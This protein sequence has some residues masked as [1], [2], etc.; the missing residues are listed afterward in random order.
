MRDKDLYQRILGIEAPWSVTDVELDL[1]DRRHGEVRVHVAGSA[2]QR[3]RHGKASPG[4]LVPKV[5]SRSAAQRRPPKT[6]VAAG[7]PGAGG[8]PRGRLPSPP[9]LSASTLGELVW[10]EWMLARIAAARGELEAAQ[11]ALD[12]VRRALL[13]V[14]SLREAASASLDLAA[15]CAEAGDAPGFGQLGDNL[16]PSFPRGSA[17]VAAGFRALQEGALR[18]QELHRRTVVLRRRLAALPRG[19]SSRPDLVCHLAR[20]VDLARIAPARGDRPAMLVN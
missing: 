5:S 8:H 19:R 7:R 17:T 9:R 20:L 12:T 3:A 6:L 4:N 18:A 2:E 11:P 15:T 14:G 10:Q 1:K 16:A 13:K